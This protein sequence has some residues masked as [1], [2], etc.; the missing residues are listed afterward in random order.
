MR[1]RA[2]EGQEEIEAE[3]KK[4]G[5]DRFDCLLKATE[6]MMSFGDSNMYT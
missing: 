4:E 5:I 2:R 1:A 6:V 3:K